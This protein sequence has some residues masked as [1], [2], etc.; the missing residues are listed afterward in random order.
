MENVL[1]AH[2]VSGV[3]VHNARLAAAMHIHKIPNV[4]TLNVA[5]FRR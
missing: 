5:D 3:Q 2:R 1:L 4:L